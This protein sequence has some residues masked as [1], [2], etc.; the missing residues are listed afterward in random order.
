[1]K[2]IAI[3]LF[4]FLIHNVF[5]QPDPTKD[6]LKPVVRDTSWKTSGFIGLNVAQ[7]SMSNWQGGGQD[8]IAFTG[9]INYQADYKKGKIEWSNK[10]D[11]QFGIVRTGNSKFWQKNVDQLLAVTQYNIKAFNKYWYYSVMADFRSQFSD[12]YKYVNDTTKVAVSRWAAPAYVQLALGLDFKPTDYFV[13]TISPIAGK[14]T[15]V[16]DQVMANNGDYGVEKAKIDTASGKIV[17]PGKKI[18]YEF[19]GRLTLKFKKDLTKNVNLDTYADF[20]DAYTNNKDQNIDIVWNTLLTI[21]ISKFFTASLSTK[22]I[23]D[24]DIVV[25]YDW[26]NDGKYDNKND[27][28]GPRAQWLSI[29]GIGF[30]Y[31]F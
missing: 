2:K 15:V 25:K 1:M 5:S 22:L 29:Y 17:T 9:I 26:N 30:G 4:T 27:I 16:N 11:G 14:L 31:K 20:F 23:Y 10:F 13:A 24:N 3:L 18:R 28:F 6:T 8:N 12:G 21:K 19:G 7:T